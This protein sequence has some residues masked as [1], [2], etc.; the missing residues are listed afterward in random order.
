ILQ[1]E[2]A[3]DEPRFMMLE[4]MHEFG[5]EALAANEEMETIRQA[6]AAYYLGLAEEAETEWESPKQAVWSERLEQ[7]NDNVRAAMLWSRERG[8]T[9]HDWELALRSGGAL[10]RFWQVRGYLSE[11]RAFLERVLAGSVGI[12]SAG[13]V[14]ALIAMEHVAVVQGDYDRVESAC[15]ESLP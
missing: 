4:T 9:G 15:K 13:H 7:E 14:K 3:G 2:Q 12:V 5:M 8:E 11:G 10:R 6:H 1:D